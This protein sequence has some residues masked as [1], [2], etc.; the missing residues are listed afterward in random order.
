MKRTHRAVIGVLVSTAALAAAGPASGQ[1]VNDCMESGG[2]KIVA[3]SGDDATFGG[4]A[5]FTGGVSVAHQVYVD[6]GPATELRFRSL[7]ANLVFC[8][9]DAHT[10]EMTGQGVASTPLGVDQLVQYRISVTGNRP[11]AQAGDRYR[12]ML[13]NGYDSG[14]QPVVHGNINVVGR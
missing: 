7:T 1:V 11:I 4:N 13:S 8:N 14:D 6:H 5:T 12:I 3:A 10:A 9:L 2:G